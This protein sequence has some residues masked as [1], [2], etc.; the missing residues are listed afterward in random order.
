MVLILMRRLPPNMRPQFLREI[1][2]PRIQGEQLEVIYTDNIQE[3][4]R[5]I[6]PQ[7]AQNDANFTG[8]VL[9]PYQR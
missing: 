2:Y 6:N 9:V 4:K 1:H 5:Y 7:E 3:A 8:M